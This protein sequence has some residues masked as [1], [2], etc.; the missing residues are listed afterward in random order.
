MFVDTAKSLSVVG[1][2]SPS[3]PPDQSLPGISVKSQ[4][5]TLKLVIWRCS[6]QSPVLMEM[7]IFIDQNWKRISV[8]F[9]CGVSRIKNWR[10]TKG[11]NFFSADR[12]ICVESLFDLYIPIRRTQRDSWDNKKIYLPP[13]KIA[14]YASDWCQQWVWRFLSVW[15]PSTPVGM[16]LDLLGVYTFRFLMRMVS[17]LVRATWIDL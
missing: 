15:F 14:V 2:N 11:C 12:R 17:S 5:R 3:S 9:L 4:R 6:L 16:S 8:F 10:A 7:N 13:W 1:F